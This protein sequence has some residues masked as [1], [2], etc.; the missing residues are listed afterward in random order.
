MQLKC[1]LQFL[2]DIVVVE[3]LLL[4]GGRLVINRV[5]TALVSIGVFF[6]ILNT[7]LYVALIT[8]YILYKLLE[9]R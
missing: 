2:R 4:K 1:T 5:A 8:I 6:R 9:Y 7:I 3:I